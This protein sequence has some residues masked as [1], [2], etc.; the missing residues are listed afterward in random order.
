MR[1]AIFLLGCL[2]L[3]MLAGCASNPSARDQTYDPI[4]KV[5]RGSYWFN[6]KLDRFV[7]KPLSDGY[8]AIV[9]RQGRVM[10]RVWR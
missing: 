2:T 9:P 6:D 1:G 4:E 3:S 5:N 8:T 7:L 10:R